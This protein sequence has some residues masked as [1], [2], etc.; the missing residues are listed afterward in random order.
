MKYLLRINNS[1]TRINFNNVNISAI[2]KSMNG[3]HVKPYIHVNV[4]Q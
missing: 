2:Y 1:G 4:I 3:V